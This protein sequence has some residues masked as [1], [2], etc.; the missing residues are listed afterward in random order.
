MTNRSLYLFVALSIFSLGNV[1]AQELITSPNPQGYITIGLGS[2]YFGPTFYS[3]ITYTS[4]N[5]IF[6]LRYLKGDEFQFNVEGNIYKPSLKIKEY[7]ILYGRTYNKGILEL[8]L[9]AGVGYVDGV[10]RGRLIQYKDY[11]ESKISTIGIPFEARFRFDFSFIG[12]GGAWYGNIN[13]EKNLSAAVFQ[14]SFK[15]FGY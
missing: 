14:L 11:E 12:L 7:G 5:N 4:D 2:G 9:S 15:L 6:E 3:G 1:F 13:H 10:D 8:S